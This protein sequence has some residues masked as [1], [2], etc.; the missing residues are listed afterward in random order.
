MLATGH[1]QG[2]QGLENLGFVNG[3]R[4]RSYNLGLAPKP[5]PTPLSG[6]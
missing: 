4:L 2:Y 1:L 3:E 5:L 6:S